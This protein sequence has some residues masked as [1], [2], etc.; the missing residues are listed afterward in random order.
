[1]YVGCY[2]GCVVD[3]GGRECKLRLLKVAFLPEVCGMMG[4]GF[5]VIRGEEWNVQFY[6][7]W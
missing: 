6:G 3:S 2:E 1:M 4:M 5:C 7:H